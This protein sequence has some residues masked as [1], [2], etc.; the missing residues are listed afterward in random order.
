M[1]GLNRVED[2]LYSKEWFTAGLRSDGPDSCPTFRVRVRVTALFWMT[3]NLHRPCC[4][5]CGVDLIN[6]YPRSAGQRLL[7]LIVRSRQETKNR[8]GVWAA[9]NHDLLMIRE[10]AGTQQL[11]N[12]TIPYS[13]SAV[14]SFI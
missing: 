9:T 2:G 5:P 4:R 7:R 1:E 8:V 14:E 6:Y 11:S 12:L 3:A 13:S 10:C